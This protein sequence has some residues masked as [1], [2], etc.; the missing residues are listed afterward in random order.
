M[1]TAGSDLEPV[2][3]RFHPGLILIG[4]LISTYR[5][6]DTA[7]NESKI[8]HPDLIIVGPLSFDIAGNASK[9]YEIVDLGFGQAET[10]VPGQRAKFI[11]KLESRFAEVMTFDSQLEMANAVHE[12]WPNEE[13]A[14]VLAF[15]VKAT[16][17]EPTKTAG[18]HG[19]IDDS[20]FADAPRRDCGDPF[21]DARE[22][23]DDAKNIDAVSKYPSEELG[24]DFAPTQRQQ[25]SSPSENKIAAADLKW[26]PSV[27]LSE[28]PKAPVRGTQSFASITLRSCAVAAPIALIAW[29]LSVNRDYAPPAAAPAASPSARSQQV[30]AK[31]P[32]QS[33]T[34]FL[35]VPQPLPSQPLQVTSTQAGSAPSSVPAQG[36]TALVLPAEE[37]A[38]LLRRATDFFAQGDYAAARP[39]LQRAA[40]GGSA[41]AALMLGAIFDPLV[42]HAIGGTGIKPENA[43]AR[44]WYEKA[45]ELGSEAA[46]RQ[47][48]RLTLPQE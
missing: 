28:I 13:T 48:A 22:P 29:S 46:S 38:F 26:E 8:F 24:D 27:Q 43:L 45:V 40:E 30:K 1:V 4:P 18:Q 42:V 23:A 44:Q 39:L 47:L 20:S 16:K 2:L 9:V 34:A 33:E 12:H 6:F 31:E 3:G 15:A 11:E 32:T 37:I 35:A 25:H 14:K 36:S 10:N 19:D 41:S 17:S 7:G 5:Y 21:V